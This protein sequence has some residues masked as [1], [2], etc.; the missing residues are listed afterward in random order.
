MEGAMLSLMT[1]SASVERVVELTKGIVAY[2]QRRFGREEVPLPAG[3]TRVL[4]AVYGAAMFFIGSVEIGQTIG[5]T[6]TP[7]VA[8]VGGLLCSG[9]SGLWHDVLEIVREMKRGRA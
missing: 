4:S 1:I 7:F 3:I 8:A 9:G 6:V 5:V 2:L